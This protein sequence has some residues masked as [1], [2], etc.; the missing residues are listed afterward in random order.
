[1]LRELIL[2]YVNK[3]SGALKE[4][5][6]TDIFLSTFLHLSRIRLFFLKL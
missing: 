1:M 5:K 4:E 3:E 2:R 6:G